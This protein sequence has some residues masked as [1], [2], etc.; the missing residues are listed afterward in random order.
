V[1][2]PVDPDFPIRSVC[3]ATGGARVD[4]ANLPGECADFLLPGA[5]EIDGFW[6]AVEP[7]VLALALAGYR[8]PQIVIETPPDE[9]GASPADGRLLFEPAAGNPTWEAHSW[10]D[11]YQV[12]FDATPRLVVALRLVARQRQ[13]L[14]EPFPA[15]V[16]LVGVTARRELA[17]E[18]WIVLESLSADLRPDVVAADLAGAVRDEIVSA[19]GH[20][21][22]GR[23]A[24]VAT[25][26]LS[27]L[28]PELW[29]SPCER[30]APLGAFGELWGDIWAW[31][32]DEHAPERLT[33]L[34]LTPPD[35]KAASIGRLTLD[36]R[37]RINIGDAAYALEHRFRRL[38]P[39]DANL[40]SLLADLRSRS[41]KQHWLITL[42]VLHEYS[43]VGLVPFPFGFDLGIEATDLTGWYESADD[44]PSVAT[45]QLNQA[46]TTLS[47][48]WL[49]D[50]LEHHPLTAVATGPSTFAGTA[51]APVTDTATPPIG[52]TIAVVS[53]AEAKGSQLDVAVSFGGTSFPMVRRD[54][55]ARLST[56]ERFEGLRWTPGMPSGPELF[57][58]LHQATGQAITRAAGFLTDEVRRISTY[59]TVNWYE[60]LASTEPTLHAM[61]AD[62]GLIPAGL[63]FPADSPML[64]RLRSELR[65]GLGRTRIAEAGGLNAWSQLLSIL[66]AGQAV[67]EMHPLGL[68]LDILRLAP[69]DYSYQLAA[70]GPE[71]EIEILI[72]A[73]I[74]G[75]AIGGT[76]EHASTCAPEGVPESSH[77]WSDWVVGTSAELG[78]S[79]GGEVEA[80]VNWF[81]LGDPDAIRTTIEW[82]P[83]D[84]APAMSNP[85]GSPGCVFGALEIKESL[86]AYYHIGASGWGESESVVAFISLRS[87]AIAV[88]PND[89]WHVAV[90]V[91]MGGGYSLGGSAA[92]NHLVYRTG[93]AELDELPPPAPPPLSVAADAAST[94]GFLAGGTELHPDAA[95][96]VA[97]AVARNRALFESPTSELQ[98][99]GMDDPGGDGTLAQQRAVV[100]YSLIRTLLTVAASGDLPR[101][102]ALAIPDRSVELPLP[103]SVRPLIEDATPDA[104]AANWER[105]RFV[106]AGRAM[107]V[108]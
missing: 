84:F 23:D 105:V 81:E 78:V 77:G 26:L 93:S 7:L 60:Q 2:E 85:L 55:D 61:L 107:V 22:A 14:P 48:W 70:I 82:V 95:A 49:D 53:A 96:H 57:E 11:D 34:L 83:D 29:E 98:I 68:L 87:G 15:P 33:D 45:M 16:S 54:R 91:G 64:R 86:A 40:P 41:F 43:L 101:S 3:L 72:G 79:I 94:V 18:E 21:W 102:S 4:E 6:D 42:C 88:G 69:H 31:V 38:R 35:D 10:I 97:L 8:C 28:D 66:A 47:G 37:S 13:G 103:G 19:L 89:G 39:R 65:G 46:G 58:H 5:G 44:A 99:E 20:A 51:N 36:S 25:G 108:V 27:Y 76:L 32:T 30:A 56:L 90:G 92:L 1:I 52:I 50:E 24:G 73:N 80:A 74:S 63:E 71:G 75:R 17:S 59:A 100:I 104:T 12:E 62:D 67:D 106:V 9:T